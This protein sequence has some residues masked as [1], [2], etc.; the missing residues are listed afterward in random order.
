MPKAPLPRKIGLNL[1][2]LVPGAVGGSEIYARELIHE[3][4]AQLENHEL[5]A[6]CVREATESLEAERWPENV[7]VKEIPIDGANKPLRAATEMLRLPR[8][9]KRDGVGLLHSL[10]NTAPP[11]GEHARVVT[12]LDLIYHHHPETFPGPAR[13]GLELLVPLGARRAHRVTTISQ[14]TKDDL[15]ETCRIDPEKV[16]P[17]LLGLGQSVREDHTPIDELRKKFELDDRA[18]VLCVASGLAHKNVPRLLEGFAAK[19]SGNSEA[20]MLVMVGHAGLD[21][22]KLRSLVDSL[23]LGENVRF[24]GWIEQADLDGLYAL[25]E[26]FVYPTLREGF[27]LPVLEAMA[28][29]VPVAC[30][31][32]T[33]LPEVAGDAAEFFNPLDARA[34]GSAIERIL[35]SAQL[36]DSL[37]ERGRAQAARF[38]WANT[39]AGTI[40]VYRAAVRTRNA[41]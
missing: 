16:D 31:N 25:A 9:A 8:I 6:Y 29:G 28:R 5:I 1:L 24:T 11:W 15:V 37:I 4:G 13:L 40:D 27:G 12:I 18:V 35:D 30:S 32:T 14:A 22:D 26:L 34:I 23:G 10:G 41:D 21:Q 20:P 7:R 2:Y 33:S 19:W 39:A 38:T 36:R 3:L 17:V